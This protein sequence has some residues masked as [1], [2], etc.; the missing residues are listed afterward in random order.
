VTTRILIVDDHGVL[1]AGLRALLNDEADLEVVGEAA[2]GSEALQQAVSLNPD[3]I[4]MDISMPDISGIEATRNLLK[5]N[6][7]FRVVILTLHE[8]TALLR[9]AFRSGAKG[10]LLKKAVEGEL[11]GAIR[12]VSE[13]GRYVYPEMTLALV[14]EQTRPQL[15][16]PETTLTLREI[17]VMRRLVKGYTNR[18]IAEELVLSVRTVETYRYSLMSKLDLHS[19]VELVEYASQHG[20]V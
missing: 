11:I 7:E 13:G 16:V 5:I 8:D 6:P 14:D 19:R 1:R 10:F 4:L 12:V 3:V 17:D 18:E 15:R 2:N 9:E 20:I